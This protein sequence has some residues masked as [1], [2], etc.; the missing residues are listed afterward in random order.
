MKYSIVY[1][2]PALIDADSFKDAIKQYIKVQ[3]N[4]NIN[5]MILTDRL[6]H[7]NAEL[8]YFRKNNVD[9]VGINMYPINSNYILSNNFGNVQVRPLIPNN[10]SNLLKVPTIINPAFIPTIINPAFIPTVVNLPANI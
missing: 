8:N 5:Q 9:K 2:Y 4:I 7:V 6:S 3:H 1:P 10:N